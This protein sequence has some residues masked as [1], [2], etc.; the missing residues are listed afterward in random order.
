[1]ANCNNKTSFIS[2]KFSVL[3][4]GHV[5]L[6]KFAKSISE[7]L[8]VGV[9]SDDLLGPEN[10]ESVDE[11]L[12]A[13]VTNKFVDQVII[14]DKD[15]N[16]TLFSLKPDLIIKGTEHKSTENDEK[17]YIDATSAQ[18][19]FS[20][21]ATVNFTHNTEIQSEDFD[22]LNSRWLVPRKFIDRHQLKYEKISSLLEATDQI[23]LLV[24]GDTIVD[25]YVECMAVGMSQEEPIIVASPIQNKQLQQ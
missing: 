7:K 20:S 8:I 1:M 16:A 9:Y 10:L 22:E 4:A 13:I 17:E 2:G 3:H 14:I 24:I 15:I 12:I 6:F 25:K 11:R 5:R 19:I 23:N 21:G 18:L